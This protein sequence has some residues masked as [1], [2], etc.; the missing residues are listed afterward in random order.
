MRQGKACAFPSAS[1][2]PDCAEH[3]SSESETGEVHALLGENGAGKS[4]LMS[5]LFGLYEPTS[6]KIPVREKQT[7]I[8]DPN[9]ANRLGIDMV[10]QHFKL[11]DVFTTL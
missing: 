1:G 9:D 4:T 3:V 8:A 10:H 7:K 2:H 6:G 5:I 11:V